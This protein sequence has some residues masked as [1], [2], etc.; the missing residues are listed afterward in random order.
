MRLDEHRLF[1]RLL[2]IALVAVATLT[3][4]LAPWYLERH[5]YAARKNGCA[6]VPVASRETPQSYPSPS[7]TR[8]PTLSDSNL[9]PYGA[10]DACRV[11]S[12][13]AH[14]F[15]KADVSFILLLETDEGSVLVRMDYYDIGA[16][17]QYVAEATELDPA[18]YDLS[19]DDVTRINQAITRRGGLRATPWVVHYGDG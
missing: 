9:W 17:R 1:G 4:L 7:S 10:V 3:A 6:D 18:G 13:A 11:L 19:E 15:G 2:V 16:G 8:R 12:S 14:L 5:R